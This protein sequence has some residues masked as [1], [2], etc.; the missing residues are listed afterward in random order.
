MSPLLGVESRPVHLH[1]H[2]EVSPV[3]AGQL[4]EPRD[5]FLNTEYEEES[6]P[7]P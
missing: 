1:F 5:H 4:Q 6:V 3:F 2:E 7:E